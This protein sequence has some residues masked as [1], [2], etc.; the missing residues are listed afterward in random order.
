MAVDLVFDPDTATLERW[1]DL[2]VIRL[3]IIE[4]ASVCGQGVEDLAREPIRASCCRVKVMRDIS[5]ALVSLAP[6]FLDR[7]TPPLKND[8]RLSAIVLAKE[9]ALAHPSEHATFDPEIIEIYRDFLRGAAWWLRRMRYVL[10]DDYCTFR[11]GTARYTDA[12]P[13]DRDDISITWQSGITSLSWSRVSVSRSAEYNGDRTTHV[14]Y[15]IKDISIT[16]PCPIACDAIPVFR[17]AKK[18]TTSAGGPFVYL[19]YSW[20]NS[21][22]AR[23]DLRDKHEYDY[24]GGNRKH[25]SYVESSIQVDFGRGPVVMWTASAEGETNNIHDTIP[26]QNDKKICLVTEEGPTFTLDPDWT[27][28]LEWAGHSGFI[29]YDERTYEFDSVL[30]DHEPFVVNPYSSVLLFETGYQFPPVRISEK[31]DYSKVII[32][33]SGTFH[34]VGDY[35]PFYPHLPTE[36]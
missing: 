21:F 6:R 11:H 22:S 35:G 30:N 20:D 14:A 9:Y 33:Y 4:R 12:G 13:T 17:E 18:C 27:D 25:Y 16:N 10:L 7:W 23:R 28:T 29:D 34:V 24:D 8:K 32:S 26:F 3:A 5:S 1:S 36:T 19:D 31:S 15:S 2:E